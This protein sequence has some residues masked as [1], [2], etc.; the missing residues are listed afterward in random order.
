MRSLVI[1]A[2]IGFFFLGFVPKEK[3]NW[4]SFGELETAL[5]EK[6]KK[7]IVHFY[8]DWCVYC[9]KM[10]EAV[11]TKPDIIEV[12][13]A[14]YYAVSFN[15]ESKD[16]IHF[17]GQTFVNLNAGKKRTAFHQIPEFLAGR[18][19]RDL[20]LPATV[21][22]DKDFNIEKRFYQYIPPKEM[23]TILKQL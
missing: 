17:G 14:D 5:T 15:V 10:E 19:D 7:V 1:I 4:L 18:K 16:S 8:A 6:P 20:E 12:L 13:N 11:Y 3:V 9:K 21:I 22:L 23:L 2:L